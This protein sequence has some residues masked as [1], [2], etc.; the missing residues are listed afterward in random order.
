MAVVCATCG[1]QMVDGTQFC[2]ACGN[3]VSAAPAAGSGFT[4]VNIPSQP[5]APPPPPPAP[6]AAAGSAPLPGYTQVN[7]GV[8]PGG[9]YAAPGAAAYVAPP[10]APVQTGGGNAVKII[11]I[12]LAIIVG[13]GILG[14]GA[15][16]FAVWRVAHSIREHARNG[17]FTINTPGGAVSGGAATKYTAEELGVDIYPGAE[18]IK[19][20]MRMN[21]PNGSIISGSFV[22][23]DSKDQVL[24]FYKSKLGSDAS[25]FDGTDSAMI[26]LKKGDHDSVMVT[27][28]NRASEQ[29]GKTKISIVH[30]ANKRAS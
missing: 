3:A 5:A 19:G 16:G 29:D 20:G 25:V 4:P 30:T 14:A 9:G 26:S 2:P 12:V 6:A 13:I 10:M 24:N 15:V 27:I 1:A 23:S 8:P 21:L 28:S 17:D 11:L 18:A 7:T 22:T